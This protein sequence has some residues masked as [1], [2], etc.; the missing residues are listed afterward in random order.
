MQGLDPCADASSWRS[1]AAGERKAAPNRER[2][3][4]IHAPITRE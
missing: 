3:P 4:K 1:D 2:K